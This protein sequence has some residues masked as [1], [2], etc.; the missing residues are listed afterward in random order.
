MVIAF[1]VD[2]VDWLE[3][4]KPIS[5]SLRVYLFIFYFSAI[6]RESL[7][8]ALSLSFFCILLCEGIPNSLS[9]NLEAFQKILSGLNNVN[10]KMISYIDTRFVKRRLCFQESV[11]TLNVYCHNA[12]RDHFYCLHTNSSKYLI[13]LVRLQTYVILYFNC[14]LIVVCPEK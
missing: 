2:L 1:G 8:H 9:L 11:F 13:A 4:W 7:T 12:A 6:A 14:L 5:R 3:V 10:C